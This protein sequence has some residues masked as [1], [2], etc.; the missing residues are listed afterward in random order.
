MHYV[1]TERK[2]RKEISR[3]FAGL[4]ALAIGMSGT[5]C[6][7]ADTTYNMTFTNSASS[8]TIG[9]GRGT[10]S[11]NSADQIASF[12]ASFPVL[13]AYSFDGASASPGD[14]L[15]FTD[16][17]SGATSN[18]YVIYNPATGIFGSGTNYLFVLEELQPSNPNN[19]AELTIH[20]G[21]PILGN[22]Y[23]VNALGDGR[24][25]HQFDPDGTWTVSG[26]GTSTPEPGSFVQLFEGL[27]A[28][29]IV[30]LRLRRRRH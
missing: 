30:S 7:R 13:K 27:S 3:V 2:H 10:L 4:T 11:I 23:G 1:S 24:F 20:G 14:V 19:G 6:L 28:V 18:G 25:T 16:I 26:P 5:T 15:T 9:N 8:P 29:A 21:E 17:V 22:E 12:K